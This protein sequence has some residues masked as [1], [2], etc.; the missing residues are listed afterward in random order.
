MTI[1]NLL[2]MFCFSNVKLFLV[3]L[4]HIYLLNNVNF[5]SFYLQ[6]IPERQKAVE[7]LFNNVYSLCRL[8]LVL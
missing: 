7:I 4:K 5:W 8:P 2:A 6:Y 1:L 3:E